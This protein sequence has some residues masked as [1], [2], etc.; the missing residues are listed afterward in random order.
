VHSDSY[1]DGSVVFRWDGRQVLF[2]FPIESSSERFADCVVD[3][4]VIAQHWQPVERHSLASVEIAV[5]SMDHLDRVEWAPSDAASSV[6][7]RRTLDV[8][9]AEVHWRLQ[10]IRERYLDRLA[11]ESS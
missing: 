1:I 5:Y 8:V 6:E 4:F 11:R 2:E 9:L 7:D 3:D 10:R